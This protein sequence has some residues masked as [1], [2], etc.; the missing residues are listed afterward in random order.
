M[1]VVAG[2]LGGI[3]GYRG[4][5]NSDADLNSVITNGNYLIYRFTNIINTPTTDNVGGGL[6]VIA[7]DYMIIQIVFV[8][9][10]RLYYRNKWGYSDWTIWNKISIT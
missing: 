1:L 9:D 4:Q 8:D 7:I 6:L 10:E 5:L 3:F 2:I